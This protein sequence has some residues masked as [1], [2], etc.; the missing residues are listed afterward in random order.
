MTPVHRRWAG[1]P[2]MNPSNTIPSGSAASIETPMQG[3]WFHSGACITQ[4]QAPLGRTSISS[5]TVVQPRGPRHCANDSGPVPARNTIS[6]GAL[7]VRKRLNCASGA[8]DGSYRLPPEG[9]AGKEFLLGVDFVP[10]F[11]QRVEALGPGTT[12]VSKPSESVV[13]AGGRREGTG[14]IVRFGSA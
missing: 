13:R 14:A 12:V 3:H 2:W 6:R 7:E 10:V 1:K 5:I 9:V 8:K 11:I 4:R